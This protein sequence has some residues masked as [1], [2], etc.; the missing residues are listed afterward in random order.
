MLLRHAD[1][2]DAHDATRSDMLRPAPP[3]CLRII[4]NISAFADAAAMRA[5]AT[6]AIAMLLQHAMLIRSPR[7]AAADCC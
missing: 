6:A 7:A 2:F 5:A 4:A 1:A 3:C